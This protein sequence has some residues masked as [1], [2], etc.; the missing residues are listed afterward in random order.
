MKVKEEKSWGGNRGVIDVTYN[1]G[2]DKVSRRD[3]REDCSSNTILKNVG[4]GEG[5][6]V[7]QG[8]TRGWRR[9]YKEPLKIL[10]Q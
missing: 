6:L 2:W 8:D 1:N 4:K 7:M 9:M 3:V 5:E 10:K